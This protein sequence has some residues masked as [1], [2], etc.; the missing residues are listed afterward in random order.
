MPVF[1][2]GPGQCPS[3]DGQAGDVVVADRHRA[4]V[5][6]RDRL[7]L[8]HD[9]GAVSRRIDRQGGKAADLVR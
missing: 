5:D 7:A 3:G 1:R 8:V 4:Q 9:D 6:L 2:A